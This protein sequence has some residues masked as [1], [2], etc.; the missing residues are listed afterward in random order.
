MPDL[1]KGLEEF[2]SGNYSRA[3]ALILPIAEAGDAEAQCLIANLYQV[4]WGVDCN[5]NLAIKWY[6]KSA[7]QGYG[8]ASNNLAEIFFEGENGTNIDIEKALFWRAKAIEQGFLHTRK[9][10]GNP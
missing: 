1:T 2:N 6:E 3:F 4:G 5:I 7:K 8:V 10:A 9:L